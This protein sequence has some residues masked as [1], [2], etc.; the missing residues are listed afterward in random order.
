MG[1]C[2]TEDQPN[3][4][5]NSINQTKENLKINEIESLK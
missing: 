1:V 3:K 2:T 4:S 5:R